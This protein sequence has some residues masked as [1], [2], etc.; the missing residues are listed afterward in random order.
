MV[1]SRSLIGWSYVLPLRD[2]CPSHFPTGFKE[3]FAGQRP[4]SV[5]FIMFLSVSPSIWNHLS[6]SIRSPSQTP[7]CLDISMIW[8][9]VTLDRV[10][11]SLSGLGAKV[12]GTESSSSIR[13]NH[14][15][16]SKSSQHSVS[17]IDLKDYATLVPSTCST[18]SRP[19]IASQPRN[20]HTRL[21]LQVRQ[22]REVIGR[23][24][25]SA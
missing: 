25:W 17:S 12:T 21:G 13:H 18:C 24:D 8:T 23:L 10:L 16:T 9:A 2:F 5:S 3:S 19:I 6:C 1:Y 20:L 14:S 11:N 15:F 7:P 22:N 4:L